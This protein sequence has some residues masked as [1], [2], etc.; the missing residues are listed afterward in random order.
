MS[1]LSNK[2]AYKFNVSSEQ[3]PEKSAV[4]VNHL[5]EK[6][7]FL[8]CPSELQVTPSQVDGLSKSQFNSSLLFS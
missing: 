6:S 5:Y 3:N 4:P 1:I 2:S 8:T 7:I